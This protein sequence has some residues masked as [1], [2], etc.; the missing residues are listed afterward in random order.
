MY[1]N[2]CRKFTATIFLFVLILASGVIRIQAARAYNSRFN[3][4]FYIKL[5]K[6]Q[7]GGEVIEYARTIPT[8]IK[9]WKAVEK[10]AVYD[11][12]TLYDYMNGGAEV[13]LAFDFRHVFVRKY[14]GPGDNEIALDIYHMGTY[15]EAFGV[16]S[17]DQEDEP[18]GVGQD[19]EYG[20]GLLRFWQGPYF[21]T[22][23]AMGD[24]KEAEPVILELGKIVASKLGPFGRKPDI[25]DILPQEKLIKDRVS[26]FHS[27]VNLN[28][29]F[30]IASENILNL[31]RKTDCVFAEYETI[32]KGRGFLLVVK[33]TNAIKAKAAYESFLG[34][35]MPEGSKS[36][37]AQMEN[38]AWTLARVEENIVSIV[39]EAPSKQWASKLQSSIKH[40]SSYSSREEKYE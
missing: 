31:H 8:D 1:F 28:N 19:S 12:K 11:R 39:F 36:G 10:D 29:R 27:N 34:S 14:K 35:Y 4:P 2:A 5:T 25:L 26:F 15:E 40:G 38:K 17:C 30:F 9:G 20:F 32:G 37:V 18:A 16:F 24:D 23:T 21:V 22:I 13:Y 6:T 7:K 33:Y 3:L